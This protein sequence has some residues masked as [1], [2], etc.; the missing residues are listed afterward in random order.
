MRKNIQLLKHIV[1]S[2]VSLAVCFFCCCYAPVAYANKS[3]DSEEVAETSSTASENG[4]H[5]CASSFSL[6]IYDWQY[7]YVDVDGYHFP[8]EDSGEFVLIDNYNI[9]FD[10]RTTFEELFSEDYLS[11]DLAQTLLDL[12][13][14][15]AS[16]ISELKDMGDIPSECK[17]VIYLKE[18]ALDKYE[19]D[20][21]DNYVEE[22]SED[23]ESEDTEDEEESEAEESDAPEDDENSEAEE[24]DAPEDDENSEDEESDEVSEDEY[25]VIEVSESDLEAGNSTID[26]PEDSAQESSE[27]I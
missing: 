23:D 8:V 13:P 3:N 16:I 10:D 20:S 19:I 18:G 27:D 11:V 21:K 22:D 2:A 12:S 17:A 7:T 5:E 6:E 25:E 4:S 26:S 1:I 15:T 9:G 24:S 14:D